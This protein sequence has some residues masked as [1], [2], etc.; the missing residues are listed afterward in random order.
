MTT[1]EP[2]SRRWNREHREHTAFLAGHG[3]LS[4]RLMR[5]EML[6]A[7]GMYGAFAI[8]GIPLP[9]LVDGA[10]AAIVAAT[11]ASVGNWA[12]R[13]RRVLDWRWTWTNDRLAWLDNGRSA[14][15]PDEVGDD[16]TAEALAP[17]RTFVAIYQRLVTAQMA[18]TAGAAAGLVTM[19]R[20][21]LSESPSYGRVG[22]TAAVLAPAVYI[23][24]AAYLRTRVDRA[25]RTV[26][27][28]VRKAA[29]SSHSSSSS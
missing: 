7:L 24:V 27:Y 22:L 28:S 4:R 14:V 29:W 16:G 1:T 13:E 9:P 17:G 20:M 21:V 18:L 12:D 8:A 5:I 23:V 3:R 6:A 19:T 26:M 10:L 15:R 2:P 25:L 11:G